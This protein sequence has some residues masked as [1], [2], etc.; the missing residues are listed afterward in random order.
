MTHR[1]LNAIRQTDGD[2]DPS[3]DATVERQVLMLSSVAVSI[4][5][6]FG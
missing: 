6:H 2:L 4:G 3:S 5:Q 1:I